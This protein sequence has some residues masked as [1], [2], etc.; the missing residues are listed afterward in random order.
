K[1]GSGGVTVAETR[2]KGAGERPMVGGARGTSRYISEYNR[3]DTITTIV[4]DSKVDSVVNAILDAAHTGSKGD[5]KI[6][7]VPVEE[8]YDIGTKQK[9]AV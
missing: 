7:V 6:F 3:T 1:A 4:D 8:S 5:G 9:G 2:G